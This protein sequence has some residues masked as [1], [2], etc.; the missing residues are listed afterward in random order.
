MKPSNLAVRAVAFALFLGA[1]G[2]SRSAAPPADARPMIVISASSADVA[3]LDPDRATNFGDL[4]VVSEIFNGLVRFTPGSADPN[5]VEPDLAID[6]QASADKTVWTF[7][8]RKGVQFHGGYGEMK[9][10]DVV[11]SVRRAADPKQ[12]SFAADFAVIDKV[13]ALDDYTVRFTLKHPS[14]A[15]LGLVANY[16]GGSV[17]SKAAVEKLGKKFGQAPIGTGPFVFTQ[18][19]TQ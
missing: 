10:D 4:G 2:V 9:A 17:L 15:F 11:F 16:H 18:L 6:W 13:E 14:A 7:H 1:H 12:S 3:T 19:V 8:L 5:A